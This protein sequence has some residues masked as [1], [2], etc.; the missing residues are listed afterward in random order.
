MTRCWS[1]KGRTASRHGS[2]FQA[3]STARTL[4]CRHRQRKCL[5]FPPHT[6]VLLLPFN[7]H[8]RVQGKNSQNQ[9]QEHTV[10][11]TWGSRDGRNNPLSD[12]G[13]KARCEEWPAWGIVSASSLIFIQNSLGQ[14]HEITLRLGG[15]DKTKEAVC[16]VY[17]VCSLWGLSLLF[18]LHVSFLQNGCKV[19]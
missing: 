16:L 9:S 15:R 17:S 13:P 1:N 6:S 12:W 2:R 10:H 18:F 3:I 5:E 11:D 7:W 19:T 4:C 8:L 14:G